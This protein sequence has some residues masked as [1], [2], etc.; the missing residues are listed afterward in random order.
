MYAFLCLEESKSND[1]WTQIA[2][3]NKTEQFK[4]PSLYNFHLLND[5]FIQF[6]TLLGKRF[7]QNVIEPNIRF[8]LDMDVSDVN[9]WIPN[10]EMESYENNC[11]DADFEQLCL[12]LHIEDY[13]T[14][15][16]K[17]ITARDIILYQH[18]SQ[19]RQH[20]PLH[21]KISSI[22]KRKKYDESTSDLKLFQ[23]ILPLYVQ[24]FARR[25]EDDNY[26]ITQSILYNNIKLAKARPEVFK[27]ILKGLVGKFRHKPNA[28]Q[29]LPKAYNIFQLQQNC[30]A[31]RAKLLK[32]LFLVISQ[33]CCRIVM[34][35]LGILLRY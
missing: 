21:R 17:E 19:I 29:N 26:P 2:H 31:K 27:A 16:T 33:K 4:D 5:I 22:G 20:L 34:N 1:L 32:F 10:Y 24:N 13:D 8:L 23:V 12:I 3:G 28:R 6:H 7:T 15:K 18:R 25:V 35:N 14:S 9:S 30:F 11:D